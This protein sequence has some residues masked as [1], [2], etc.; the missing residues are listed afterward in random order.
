MSFI[1]R[2]IKQPVAVSVGV[3]LLVMF[4]VISVLKVPVQLTP[5]VDQP[6]ISVTTRWFGASPQEIEREVVEE[7]EE[8]LKTISGLKQMTSQSNEGEGVVRLEFE[9]GVDKEAALNE[10]RDKL[11]QVP[12]YPAEVDEPVVEAVDRWSRDYIAW[13]LIRPVGGAEKATIAPGAA[14]GFTGDVTE[15]QDFIEDE[16]KPILERAEGVSEVQIFGGREREGQVLVD[17]DKL[18]A[19]GVTLGQLVTAVRAENADVSAGTIDEGKR[20]TSVR[21]VGQFESPEQVLSTVITWTEDGAPVYVRDVAEFKQS[22]KKQESFVRSLGADVLALNAQREPGSNVIQV[23]NNL[24]ARIKEVNDNILGPRKWGLE[25]HQVYDQ[26]VY[27]HQSIDNARTDLIIGGILALAVLFLTLR[28]V[29]A[30]LVVGLSIPISIIGTFLGMYLTGRNLNVVSMAGLAFAIGMGV[31]NTIVVLENIFRHREMGKGRLAAALDGTREVW[32]AIVAATLANIAVF[33]PVVFIQQEA[34]QLFRDISIAISISLFL[35]MAVS[36]T[37]IPMLATL[38]LRRMPGGFVETKDGIAEREPTTRLG[39]LTRPLSRAGAASSEFF[40]HV[41]YWLTGGLLRRIVL[42]VV[43]IGLALIGS[44]LLMPPRT[45]VPTGNQNLM[46]SFVVTPPG[47][48]LE[49]LRKMGRRAEAVLSPWWSAKEGSPELKQ[50]QA[51]W[52]QQR[53]K[54]MVPMLENMI[55]GQKE[56]LR[57]QGLSEA[58]IEGAV[59]MFQTKLDAVKN[60]PPPS[61][62][63]NFFFVATNAGTF[64]GATSGDM[65]NVAPISFLFEAAGQGEPGTMVIA[66]Q[67]PIFRLGG[68][69]SGIEINI[70][71]PDIDK[72]RNAAGAAMGAMMGKYHRFVLSQPQNFN[73]PR[74]E[75]QVFPDKEKAARVGL[76][77]RDVR[78]VSQVAVD[79]EVIGDYRVGG[80]AIDLTVKMDPR[81]EQRYSHA[82]GI[83]PI[84]T[85]DGRVIQLGTVASFTD[86]SAPQQIDRLEERPAVRLTFYLQPGETVEEM[87]TKLVNEVMEPLRQS[88]MITPDMTIQYTGSAG[89]LKDFLKE[90]VGDTSSGLRS[91]VF[92]PGIFILAAIITYLLLAALFESWLHPFTIIMSVPFALVGGF[93]GLRILHTFEPSILL[94]VLTMLGFVILIG[95]IVNNPILIVHQAL[96][97]MK[98]GMDRRQAIAHSTQTRVRP[99]F[100]SVITSVAG[101]APLVVFGGAGSELYR[102]LGSVVVGGLLVSTIFTLLLTPTLM[103]LMLD[104]QIGL[105]NF[106]NRGPRGGQRPAPPPSDDGDGEPAEP[107]HDGHRQPA[108]PALAKWSMPPETGTQPT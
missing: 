41:V 3:L 16:V 93:L 89:K 100:M 42:V 59:S 22:F 60:S 47:Y 75:V 83:A 92:S 99:I 78:Q 46:F 84:A 58:Q 6:I 105:R 72:V 63:E 66:Q 14:A 85:R 76:T 108:E 52:L 55:A 37:V 64:M 28:S 15:L 102:G 43:M 7:Q 27:V 73:I 33:L 17:L 24:K 94:D 95:T 49:E 69:G 107:R 74:N 38:F 32:G 101:M 88:G 61:S 13:M 2:C 21:A 1:E 11:R 9:V 29:G 10:V 35:Y 40:H 31:D 4:G 5:N 23:M 98:D 8:F 91:W 86:T 65:Q 90:F 44:I 54:M 12:E 82:L 80:R 67:M 36:P 18:A 57:K 50:L 104:M 103:S 87:Q 26:T 70:A 20:R 48:N 62:I 97:N 51:G 53:D 71:G 96:N 30:T 106:F 19:R 56:T 45:Y 81:S 25:L 79:G 77:G 68:F 39:R 34:G